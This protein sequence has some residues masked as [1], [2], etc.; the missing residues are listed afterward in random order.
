MMVLQ[1]AV[2]SDPKAL[3]RKAQDLWLDDHPGEFPRLP[4]EFA[5]HPFSHKKHRRGSRRGTPPLEPGHVEVEKFSSEDLRKEAKR[6]KK[7][8]KKEERKSQDEGPRR[9][10]PRLVHH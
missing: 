8:K 10:H 5:S 1:R 6:E 4:P 3:L 2:W 7:A 9:G